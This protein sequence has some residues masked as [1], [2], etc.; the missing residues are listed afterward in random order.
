MIA[1]KKLGKELAAWQGDCFV[2]VN[3]S[4]EC[5]DGAAWVAR[6][7]MAAQFRRREPAYELCE[8]AARE[9]ER[10]TSVAG[11]VCYIPPGTPI[12]LALVPFYDLSQVDLR[13]FA[14]IPEQ[15]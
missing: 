10:L 13:D 4:G 1:P 3:S 11:A 15:C 9:A 8:Q 14:L 12:L 5:W 2:V 6:W 7:S